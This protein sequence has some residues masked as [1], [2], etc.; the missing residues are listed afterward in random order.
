MNFPK[1]K[2]IVADDVLDTLNAVC[3]RISEIAPHIQIV[4]RF[5]SLSQTKEA[6][7]MHQPD[8]LITDIRF[9]PESKTIFDL[10][11]TYKNDTKFNFDVVIFTGH[12]NELEYLQKSYDYPNTIHF[13]PKPIDN[14]KLKEALDRINKKDYTEK[15][16]YISPSITNEK[17][18]IRTASGSYFIDISEIVYF[19]TIEHYTHFCLNETTTSKKN[20]RSSYNIG[21]YFDELEKYPNFIRIHDSIVLNTNYM[22]G[23]GKK[24]EREVI[25]KEPFGTLIASKNKFVEL[26]QKL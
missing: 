2:A 15:S 14:Q 6:I 7:E 22:I 4:G 17:L 24:C 21:H 12:Y 3:Q 9:V 11:E 1:I 13:I 25:L 18:H 26:L 10:L 23:I 20:I 8:V 19:K 16:R 5:T